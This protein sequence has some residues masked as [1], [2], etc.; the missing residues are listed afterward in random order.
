[1]RRNRLAALVCAAVF[2]GT[3]PAGELRLVDGRVIA[4]T[5]SKVDAGGVS[6]K[7]GDSRETR[8]ALDLVARIEVVPAPARN[9]AE[10]WTD[11]EMTDGTVIRAVKVAFA[12]D[13]VRAELAGG[14]EAVL[15]LK[16]VSNMLFA[17]HRED[18]RKD[19]TTRLEKGKRKDVLAVLRQEAVN[20]LEGTLGEPDAEGK[21]V[22]FTPA[23]SDRT[24]PVPVGNIHGLVFGRAP[25]PGL[26]PVAA[27]VTDA[28]GS[29][30]LAAEVAFDGTRWSLRT[31]GGINRAFPAERPPVRLDM[32][33]GKVVYLSDMKWMRV[34]DPRAGDPFR[35]RAG[36]TLDKNLDLGP[37]RM[38]GA[39]FT[40]GLGLSATTE[41]EYDLGGEYRELRLVAGFDDAVGGGGPV[42]LRV[43]GDGKELL[44]QTVARLGRKASM[45]LVAPVKDVRRLTIT[46]EP[47]GPSDIAY[48]HHLHLGDARLTR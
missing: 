20:S 38:G 37:I 22:P 35:F 21:V 47:P 17:A 12:R 26:A 1:M 9:L 2:L 36:P 48:G 15:P 28:G 5:P 13:T 45:P 40:K 31:S 46:V 33:R 4:G 16:A 3:A 11:I 6:W 44:R 32:S 14:G 34:T 19:W 30:W 23:G 8:I 43:E 42:V 29:L 18:W 39:L 10:S 25:D 27:R 24:V 41:V 7:E